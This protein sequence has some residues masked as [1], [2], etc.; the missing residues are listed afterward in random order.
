MIRQVTALSVKAPDQP[1][2]PVSG[3]A[4]RPKEERLALV[5]FVDQA[6]LRCLRWLRK[7][8]RHC[9]VIVRVDRGWIACDP[10]SHRTDLDI[11]G[12]FSADQLAH[13]YRSLGLK[14]VQTRVRCAPS[15]LAPVRP[16]TCVEAVKHVLGLHAPWILTPWQLYKKL[17]HEGLPTDQLP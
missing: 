11:V 7:G 8:F 13:W 17:R 1:P 4:A 9:F 14:V 3:E 15:R 6:G 12:D 16:Y 5:V 2:P 10:M